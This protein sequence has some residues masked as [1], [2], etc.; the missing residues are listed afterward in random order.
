[1]GPTVDVPDP[2]PGQMR[3]QLG[4]GDARMS[5]QLLDDPQVGPALEQVR[6]ERVP[7]RVRADPAA[8]AGPSRRSGHRRPG[9][10]ARQPAAAIAEEQRSAADRRHV[11]ARERGRAAARPA[12][13]RA[14]RGR[15]RRS[16]TRRS[17]SPL[18]MTRTNA[19]SSDR[20]SRSSPIASLTRR[21]A[22]YS[23]SSSARSRTPPLGGGLEEALHLA[24]VERVREAPALAGQVE[25]GRDVDLDE[26]LAEREPV[27]ALERG[28]ASSEAGRGE[29]RLARGGPAACGPRG[30]AR[31]GRASGPTRRRRCQRGRRSPR[32]RR[33]TP[34][35]W[36]ARG[37]ARRAR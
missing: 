29:A 24:D 27:E 3:V 25:V 21:P 23:S 20:S 19:P 36:P 34:G 17:L 22:A 10:L 14:S 4:R 28:G 2:L 33:G 31:P 9:R 26:A 37:P 11:A 1:M 15:P 30:S 13:R 7:E 35:S 32:G 6:R 8:E 18:P 5:E 12:R 16:G